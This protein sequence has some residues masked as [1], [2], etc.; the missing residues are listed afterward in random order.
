MP[1]LIVWEGELSTS[2]DFEGTPVLSHVLV[3]HGFEQTSPCGGHGTCGKCAVK[4]TGAISTQNETEKRFGTRLSCQIW[5]LGDCEVILPVKREMQ[6]I[7][8]GG[9]VEADEPHP[10]MGRLGAAID[11]GTTTLA[12]RLYDLKMGK[13]KGI[14]TAVNPQTVVSADVMGRIGAAVN[15]RLEQ[16][17]IMLQDTLKNMLDELCSLSGI[18]SDAVDILVAT[19]NTTMLYLLTGRNPQAFACAPFEAD[20]LFG[21]WIELLGRRTFLPQCIGAFVGADI[22][23]AVL[24]S[25][26]CRQEETS[27]LIDVGT[28]GEIALWHKGKLYVTSTAAGPA[29]EGSGIHMGCGS[30]RGAIDKVWIDKDGICCRTIG[31]G[32]AMGICG[33]GLI[34]AVAALLR[35]GKI[36]ETGAMAE[37]RLYL[38]DGVC[39]IPK[40]IRNVQLAKGA[41][42][43]G[44]KT[45][46]FEV[47][48]ETSKIGSL[49]VAGGFG[50]HIDVYNA[51]AIG[52][53]PRALAE[54]VKVIGNAALAG[55][56]LLLLRDDFVQVCA[57]LVQAAT[58]I[59]LGGSQLFTQH[60]MECMLF[61]E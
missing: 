59:N 42:A 2:V 15:G 13:S 58:C 46:L 41:I 28:N 24:A 33:S 43:A 38:K 50:S 19:G 57:D 51:A 39:L 32:P 55:A 6:Q 56:G 17:R 12:M 29:F 61:D 18:S 35:A 27:L 47:G 20:C 37:Q 40:D 26:M 22:T 9:E 5:L 1:R 49:Y 11:I 16:M 23:C 14:I 36:D 44:I 31:N 48:V 3:A 52:L 60:Y 7:E 34:D 54:K 8:V 30:V 4:A 45:L 25:G 53:I 10:M 21:E